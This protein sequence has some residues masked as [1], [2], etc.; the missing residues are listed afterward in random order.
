MVQIPK[1]AI[2]ESQLDLFTGHR[3]R[4]AIFEG[5]LDLLLYLVQKHEV[6]IYEVP[7]AKI[8]EEYL[9]Y[10]GTLQQLSV[11]L[12]GEFLVVA[13]A[14]LLIKSRMLLPLEQAEADEE[15]ELDPEQ[16]LA[17]RL[18]EYRAYK[19]ASDLLEESRRLR[20]RIYLRPGEDDDDVGAGWVLLDDVSVFDLVGAFRELL[21]KATEP[22]PRTVTREQVTVGFQIRHILAALSAASES[23][24]TFAEVITPPI[25][26]LVVIVT[27]LAVLEL[28]RRRRIHVRQGADGQIRI[29]PRQ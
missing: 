19:E 3:V 22:E 25:T 1:Y 10:L 26:K 11:E 14:L 6:D 2:D 23:G 8:T 15:E 27:F 21:E 24:L 5:P 20:E 29:H 4:I 17:Q 12:A 9:A 13:A 28:I 7:L 16:E 18:L